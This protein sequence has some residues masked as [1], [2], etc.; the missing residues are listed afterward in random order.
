[1][2]LKLEDFASGDVHARFHGE[3]DR[4]DMVVNSISRFPVLVKALNE[5]FSLHLG[6]KVR[7]SLFIC[8]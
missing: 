5:V 6:I 4:L 1:M 8:D 3:M 2:T 7:G